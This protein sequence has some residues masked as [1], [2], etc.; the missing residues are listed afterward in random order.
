MVMMVKM[1]VID[2]YDNDGDNIDDDADH[3]VSSKLLSFQM[4]MAMAMIKL[5]F[6]PASLRQVDL[7]Q[8]LG[9]ICRP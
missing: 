2:S 1:T 4:A 9:F 7:L 3:D 5:G 8:L 6:C